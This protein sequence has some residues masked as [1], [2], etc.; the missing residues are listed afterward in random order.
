M[1]S[2][3]TATVVTSSVAVAPTTAIASSSSAAAAAVAS[4]SVPGRPRPIDYT[5]SLLDKFER[6]RTDKHELHRNNYLNETVSESISS[7][8]FVSSF[9]INIH[10]Y[11]NI[12]ISMTISL[13]MDL[14]FPL[15]WNS[16][17]GNSIK[18]ASE[19]HSHI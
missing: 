17:N 8:P 9:V 2:T 10:E 16:K 6:D 3:P 14:V 4:S 13:S 18:V 12:H 19:I 11:Q 1:A 15:T 7:R 5:A